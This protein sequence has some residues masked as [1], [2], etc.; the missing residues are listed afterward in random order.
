MAVPV[1]LF[2]EG[3]QGPDRHFPSPFLAISM[4]CGAISESLPQGASPSVR[5][6][7]EHASKWTTLG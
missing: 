2:A 3:Q 5:S 6:Q 1:A 4:A 7:S